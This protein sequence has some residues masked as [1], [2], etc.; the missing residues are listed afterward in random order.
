MSTTTHTAP[1]AGLSQCDLILAR[2]RETPGEWVSEP[3]LLQVSGSHAVHARIGD[4]RKRGHVEGF[5]IQNQ[6]ERVTRP[7]GRPQ[8]HSSYRIEFHDADAQD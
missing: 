4:L 5:T 7:D 8:I 1:A 6:C 2:L 3:E